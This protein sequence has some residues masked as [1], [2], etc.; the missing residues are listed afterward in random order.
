MGPLRR[1]SWISKNDATTIDQFAQL[2]LSQLDVNE[3]ETLLDC[4]DKVCGG[5][6]FRFQIDVL[7]SPYVYINLSNFRY[8]SLKFGAHYK[9]ILI[10]KLA[11][12]LWLQIIETTDEKK[13]VRN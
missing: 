13:L 10:S 8:I 7:P 1:R 5:F 3:Y 4:H 11:N 6:D 12:T 9:T 2:L